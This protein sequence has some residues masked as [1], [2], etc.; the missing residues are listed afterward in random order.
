LTRFATENKVTEFVV[1]MV[2]IQSTVV[3]TAK[4][5]GP[6]FYEETIQPRARRTFLRRFFKKHFTITISA[7]KVAILLAIGDREF[8]FGELSMKAGC[9]LVNK[10]YD[11]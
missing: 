7:R 2:I 1:T 5:T 4:I 10:N 8:T 3:L 6:F 11:F 9:H